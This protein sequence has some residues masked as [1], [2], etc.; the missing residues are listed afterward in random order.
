MTLVRLHA[1]I[2][3][4]RDA[5]LNLPPDDPLLVIKEV[6]GS[7]AADLI[8]P[9]FPRSRMILLV[10]DG[11]DAVDSLVDA[12][13]PDG[14]LTKLRWRGGAFQ[15]E[16]DRRAFVRRDSLN[17]RARIT[18]CLLAFEKHDPQLRVKVRYEDLL[19][20]TERRLAELTRWLGLPFGP[21][22]MSMIAAEH[23][24]DKTPEPGR[25]PG[26]LWRAARPGAWREGLTPEEQQ[27]ANE[28]M[29]PVLARL[30]YET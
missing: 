14:W 5:G 15:N 21:Q 13:R 9:L 22:R 6:N 2:E 17:W 8:S 19:V 12:N 23:A 30:G 24:F 1:V 26:K 27:T 16:Q 4:A 20:G 7:H 18:A 11:R 29:G 28:V 3:R 10:R 25:G